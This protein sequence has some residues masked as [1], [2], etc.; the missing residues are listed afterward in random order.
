MTVTREGK[1]LLLT[2]VLVGLAALNTGNNLIYL[3]LALMMALGISGYLSGLRNV[4]GLKAEAFVPEPVY[5]GTSAAVR[6]QLNSNRRRPAFL[7]QMK[8]E[9]PEVS[10]L[11][12]RINPDSITETEATVRFERRGRHRVDNGTLFSSFPFGFFRFSRMLSGDREFVVYP[13]L[14]DVRRLLDR[15]SR[16]SGTGTIPSPAGDDFT[17]LRP[18][19]PGDRVRD[20]HWKATAKTGEMVVREFRA[21]ITDRVALILD[22]TPGGDPDTFEKAVSLTASLAIALFE[23][24]YMVKLVTGREQTPYCT[25]RDRICSLMD[26]LALV[27][28]DATRPPVY[29]ETEGNLSILILSHGGSRPTGTETEVVYADSV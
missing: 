23:Q 7:V 1:G 6:F 9:Q 4:N 28:Q 24:G 5:A 25:D 22:D 10:A 16:A 27:Q 14:V 12:D 29:Q 13:E 15:F 3:L 19:R 2:T 17:D 26:V 21:G 8:L 11:V 20:I 18:Y